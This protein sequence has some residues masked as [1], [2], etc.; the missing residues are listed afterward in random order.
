MIPFYPQ[1]KKKK[2]NHEWGTV[3]I[4]ASP[5]KEIEAQTGN[6]I[7]LLVSDHAEI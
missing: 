1:E 3:P 6:V 4:S 2:K 7:C 5:C